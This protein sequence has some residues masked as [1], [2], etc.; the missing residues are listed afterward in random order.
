MKTNITIEELRAMKALAA[1]TNTWLAWAEI[2]MEFCE[3]CVEQ[4]NLKPEK[5]RKN[6]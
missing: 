5:R 1:Q 6:D 3:Q 2:A 4:I